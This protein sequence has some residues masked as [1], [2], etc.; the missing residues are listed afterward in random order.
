MSYNQETFQLII[1]FF[2]K[3][4]T[5]VVKTYMDLQHFVINVEDDNDD[6]VSE[7]FNLLD[8]DAFC[9]IDS[10]KTTHRFKFDEVYEDIIVA[11]YNI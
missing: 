8:H 11:W 1:N 10:D 7:Y 6:F 5:N 4:P 3:V 2:D 9:M